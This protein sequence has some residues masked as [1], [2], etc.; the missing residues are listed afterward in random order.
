M[1]MKPVAGEAK[2]NR[3]EGAE[4]HSGHKAPAPAAGVGNEMKADMKGALMGEPEDKNPLRSASHELKAQ[5]PIEY[6][7]HGP[8]HGTDHHVRH[9]PVGKV[10]GR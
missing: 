2:M 10:Y 1:K 4:P 8:H 7:D 6:H 3:S 5:H 9:E